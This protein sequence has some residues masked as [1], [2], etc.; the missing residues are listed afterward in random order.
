MGEGHGNL[1]IAHKV[2]PLSYFQM[3]P[4]VSL[5]MSGPWPLEASSN[6]V[7]G[8]YTEKVKPLLYLLSDNGT[9]ITELRDRIS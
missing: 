2:L 5:Q 7:P 6:S 3:P 8:S 1:R 4:Y 9:F